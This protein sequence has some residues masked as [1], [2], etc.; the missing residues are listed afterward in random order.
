LSN[1]D[2]EVTA[3][4]RRR[5]TL[6]EIRKLGEEYVGA[7][8]PYSDLSNLFPAEVSRHFAFYA[9]MPEGRSEFWGG[10][11][12]Q[13]DW[14]TG[15][16]VYYPGPWG[17]SELR[18]DEYWA[19]VVARFPTGLDTVVSPKVLDEAKLRD[20]CER[21]PQAWRDK[22]IFAF[23]QEPEDNFTT[24][25]QIADFRATVKRAGQI[26]RPYGIRNAVELQEWSLNPS[27]STY[28]SGMTN[29]A[30]FVDPADI[31]HISWSL[32]EKNLKNRSTEMVGR[33]K[34][35]MDLFPSLTWDMSATGVSVPVGTPQDDPKRAARAAIVADFLRLALEDD[36]CTGFGW[37]DFE[38]SSNL[39]YTADTALKNAFRETLASQD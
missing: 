39:S 16:F 6:D 21:L 37:F 14:A 38:W 3:E 5:E 30:R 4:I 29:T 15:A 17:H 32:Y 12:D 2:A 7:G 36:R 25:S 20:F 9:H 34:A 28:P 33:V 22:M 31:D 1:L 24:E 27:N 18:W 19:D 26:V 11:L 8:H 35:F 13:R 10:G 23:Y